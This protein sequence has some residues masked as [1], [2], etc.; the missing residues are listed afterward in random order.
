MRGNKAVG[1]G[2]VPWTLRR[3]ALPCSVVRTRIAFRYDAA[4]GEL[5]GDGISAWQERRWADGAGELVVRSGGGRSGLDGAWVAATVGLLCFGERAAES[6]CT[7]GE[8][9]LP[10]LGLVLR[11]APAS[12]DVEMTAPESAEPVLL[13]RKWAC[14]GTERAYVPPSL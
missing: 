8:L 2:H 7:S 3:N 14:E 6:T 9:S 1:R 10:A 5:L 13:R 4:A 12:L 11:W